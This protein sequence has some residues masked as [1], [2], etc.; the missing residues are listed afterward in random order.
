MVF[1]IINLNSLMKRVI[2]MKIKSL[3]ISLLIASPV[4]AQDPTMLQGFYW[5]TYPGGTWYD[6][7]ALRAPQM[8]RAGIKS[9]WLPPLSKGNAGSA[10]VGYTPY[11][12]YDLGEFDSRGGD[13]TSGFG[14]Y[15]PTRYGSYTQLKNAVDRLHEN[16][17]EVYAD[18]VLNHRSGGSSEINPYINY[19]PAGWDG[20][21]YSFMDSTLNP[22]QRVTFTAFPLSNGSGRV[23]SQKGQGAQYVF[24][25]GSINPDNT[26]DFFGSQWGYFEFY[27]NTFAYDNALHDWHGNP[28]PM[29]DSLMVW[30]DWLTQ[31]LGLDG[32][33]FDFVK[34]I[35]WDYLKKWLDYGSM[36]GKFSVG[37]LYDGDAG[38]LKDWLSKMTGSQASASVFDFNLRFGYKEWSDAGHN[39]D[40]RNLNGRGLVNQ[41]VSGT[42]VVTFVDN[43]DFDRLDYQGNPTGDGHSPVI[44]HK[45]M[46]YSHLL[47]HPGYACVWWRDYYWYGLRDEINKLMAIRKTYV[48][49][50]HEILTARN[51]VYWPGNS[52]EDPKRVYVM[53]RYGIGGKTGVIFAMNNSSQW[54]IEVWVTAFDWGNKKLYDITGNSSDTLQVYNDNR[55]LIKTKANSYHIW[56][57]TDFEKPFVTDAAV[58]SVEGL[59]KSFFEDDSV[60]V[61]ARIENQGTFTAT[62]LPVTLTIKKSGTQVRQEQVVLSKVPGE[63]FRSVRFSA[64]K[65]LTEGSYTAV[66]SVTVAGDAQPADNLMEVPF[67][68]EKRPV[69]AS[70]TVDGDFSEPWYRLIANKQN[71]NA[72]FGPG[73]DVRALYL[74]WTDDSLY[75][76]IE[77]VLDPS[78]PNGDGMG[79]ILN[80]EAWEGAPAGTQI[81]NVKGAGHF[82]QVGDSTLSATSEKYKM[83]METDLAFSILAVSQKAVITFASYQGTNTPVGG[84]LALAANGAPLDGSVAVAGPVAHASIP[85]R[86]FRYA[87]NNA[88]VKKKGVEIAI[89]RSVLGPS[90]PGLVSAFAFI[91][92]ANAYFSNVSVPGFVVG[93]ADT[94]KNLGFNPDFSTLAGGPYR[95]CPIDIETGEFDDDCVFTSGP[96]ISVNKDSLL[97]EIPETTIRE[98]KLIISEAGRNKMVISSATLTHPAFSVEPAFPAE[99]PFGGNLEL[100]LTAD[101]SQVEKVGGSY[102]VI[103]DTLVIVNN[104]ENNPEVRIPIELTVTAWVSADEDSRPTQFMLKPAYPNPFNPATVLPIGLPMASQVTVSLTDVLGRVVWQRDAGVVPAG[105]SSMTIPGDGLSSGLYWIRVTAGNRSLVQKV[106]F[107]K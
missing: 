8:A 69:I 45:P 38:R 16:G 47:T 35:H 74:G 22:P 30:G 25:N 39:Y 13:Q 15:I 89:S 5:N 66:V 18:I 107:V 81:G 20:S 27:R 14:A 33:R 44:G 46:I 6:S 29:G 63:D 71:E 94:Y 83:D 62:N 91:L 40:V 92:S 49:G 10:D 55:V 17:V 106:V 36:K 82:L 9:V 56:V 60:L 54:P 41:G 51:D 21:L 75:I 70:F 50:S 97:I 102:P 103:Y 26:F 86:S 48:S 77:G 57:P 23:S 34:G 98:R 79:L 58:L 3:L 4:F 61:S 85:D 88:G 68:I 105:W 96:L 67:T 78:N 12:Y 52:T 11:D 99:I 28:L 1:P 93:T 53:R 65:G 73:K 76:G 32:Y 95:S 87:F 101:A 43:H 37:E 64:V 84:I 90:D 7:L 80:T 31:R 104:S 59:N 19:Y 24:P 2:P 100:T 72:G 42:R